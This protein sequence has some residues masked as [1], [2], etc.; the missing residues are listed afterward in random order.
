MQLVN[1]VDVEGIVSGLALPMCCLLLH[2]SA[3]LAVGVLQVG[4][5]G[6]LLSGGQKQRVAIARAIIKDP[7]VCTA[8]P[9]LDSLS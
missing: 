2:N 8:C 9:A 6:V 5:G 4:S 1:C 7:K 3:Q